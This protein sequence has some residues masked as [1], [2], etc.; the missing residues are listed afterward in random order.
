MKN[1][2]TLFQRGKPMNLTNVIDE[3]KL[4]E[5]AKVEDGARIALEEGL[6]VMKNVVRQICLRTKRRQSQD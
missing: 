5:N 4:W 1:E 3:E 2:G 6:Q